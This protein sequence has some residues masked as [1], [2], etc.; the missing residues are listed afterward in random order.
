MKKKTVK[1]KTKEP[2]YKSF[3]TQKI[4]LNMKKTKIFMH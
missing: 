2:F 1:D 3:S 4:K